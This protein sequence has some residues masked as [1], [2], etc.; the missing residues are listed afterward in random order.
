[1][2][3]KKGLQIPTLDGERRGSKQLLGLNSNRFDMMSN[4][5]RS[6]MSNR[7]RG[8]SVNDILAQNARAIN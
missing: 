5:G 2:S 1:M 6:I 8:P 4:K 7:S 3:D